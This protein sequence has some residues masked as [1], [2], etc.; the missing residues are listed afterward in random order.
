MQIDLG[1]VRETGT[2]PPG[3]PPVPYKALL[4][5]LSVV[6]AGLL[7]GAAHRGPPD[8]PTIVP[9][10][11]G[12]D[13]WVI[14]D[15]LYVVG[16]GRLENGEPATERTVT[17]YALPDVELVSRTAVP[18]EG[19]I[20]RIEPAGD[21]LLVSY[22]FDADGTRTVVAVR[23][24]T[25][26]RLWQRFVRLVDASP[27]AGTVLLADDRRF[28]LADLA[29][30]ALRWRVD[31]PAD[32]F[33]AE[34][35]FRSGR[36]SWLVT[37]TDSGRLETRDARTGRVIATA[38]VAGHRNRANGQVWPTGDVMLVQDGDEYY[39]FRLPEL[40][41]L[42]RTDADIMHSWGQSDCG[43]VLCAY[44]MER[45]I[46]ALD[47]ATG[48][49]RWTSDRWAYA[50][51]AGAYLLASSQDRTVGTPW[52]WV[53]DPATGTV[54]GDFGEWQG[55]GPAA[56]GR[57]YGVREMPGKYVISYGVLDPATRRAEILGQ[58][59]MI[60]GGCQAAAGVLYCRRVDASIAVWRLG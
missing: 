26:E 41:R 53:L 50:E 52:L 23:T 54:L 24:G 30:G 8:E 58:A 27:E 12:D 19:E 38:R 25:G 29:T 21:V 3:R 11:I 39:G 56:D 20:E 45:G 35:G 51:A 13:T 9:A 55:A 42:W 28:Y 15:R 32:G 17:G 43:V 4:A 37:V 7:G 59:G 6:L 44:R 46:M 60:S 48:V 49:Q 34:A 40:T 5:A 16:S 18:L 33:V 36:A 57:I 31:R 14:G 1:E 47:P 10:R 22:R 2:A